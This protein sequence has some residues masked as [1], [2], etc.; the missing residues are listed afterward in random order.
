[1][2]I[3]LQRRH[4]VDPRLRCNTLVHVPS[5]ADSATRDSI[6]RELAEAIA[7]PNLTLV[8]LS[9]TL[10]PGGDPQTPSSRA[11]IDLVISLMHQVYLDHGL[12]LP[13]L[14]LEMDHSPAGHEADLIESVNDTIETACVT[15][16]FPRPS[17]TFMTRPFAGEVTGRS[18]AVLDDTEASTTT[19]A[20][21]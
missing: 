21:V 3:H 6:G 16:R 17:I 13:E 18:R 7:Q 1:M 20:D 9:C 2:T 5:R 14:V 4:R 8:G 12:I 10:H 15:Y 11:T 19:S